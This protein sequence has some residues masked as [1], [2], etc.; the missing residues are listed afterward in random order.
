M[1]D[2]SLRPTLESWSLLQQS[3]QLSANQTV[4]GLAEAK[5]TQQERARLDLFQ[6]IQEPILKQN[7]RK[8]NARHTSARVNFSLPPKKGPLPSVS[9]KRGSTSF[10]T[11]AANASAAAS[12]SS[13]EADLTLAKKCGTTLLKKASTKNA[14]RA[15]YR[16]FS[17]GPDGGRRWDGW[18]S[19]MNWATMPDSVMMFPL[20]ERLGTRPRCMM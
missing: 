17:T 2:S 10:T 5:D 8:E 18:A 12:R 20:Y 11:A 3:R 1:I 9:A 19:A 15:L 6:S 4:L 13:S 7:M 16:A 14:S